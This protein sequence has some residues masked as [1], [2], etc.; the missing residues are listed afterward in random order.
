MIADAGPAGARGPKSDGGDPPA[1][2]CTCL[3]SAYATRAEAAA[4]GQ[5]TLQGTACKL[6]AGRVITELW[7]AHHTGL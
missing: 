2:S 4:V 1:N 6:I 7:C 5:H 3:L